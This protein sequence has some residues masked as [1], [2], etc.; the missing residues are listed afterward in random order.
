M[1]RL[2]Y[3][4]C[5]NSCNTSTRHRGLVS[6]L[7]CNLVIVYYLFI[8]LLDFI[9]KKRQ[10]RNFLLNL[11]LWNLQGIIMA[12]NSPL[13]LGVQVWIDHNRFQFD[14]SGLPWWWPSHAGGVTCS[15]K[16][17]WQ[18][19][20]LFL[21]RSALLFWCWYSAL[22]LRWITELNFLVAASHII[23][24]NIA[25]LNIMCKDVLFLF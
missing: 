25:F 20:D 4:A 18:N 24:P 11:A 19:D 3:Y 9:S 13:D 15:M 5:C 21:S 16:T 7:D 6:E 14:A 8:Q 10:C 2:Q 22:V 23:V 1:C 12:E 17:I